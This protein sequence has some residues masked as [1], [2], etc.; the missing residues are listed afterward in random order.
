MKHY[1]G[2]DY[3]TKRV[4]VAISSGSSGATPLATFATE[5]GVAEKELLKLITEREITTLVVG[6][7]LNEQGE[8]TEQCD[9]IE[10]FCRRITRRIKIELIY[11]DE[12]LTTVEAAERLKSRG[13]N[14]AKKG[15]EGLLDQTAATI[16]LQ[17]Y[18]DSKNI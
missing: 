9:K 12:H 14:P 5:S 17:E 15:N 10:R 11:V 13:I 18:L 2:I 7:P 16:I 1:L 6:L 4:G 8:R 3:G